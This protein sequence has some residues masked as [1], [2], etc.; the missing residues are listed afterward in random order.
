MHSRVRMSII[1]STKDFA[2]RVQGRPMAELVIGS[3]CSIMLVGR[4]RSGLR[5]CPQWRLGHLQKLSRRQKGWA[6]R[7]QRS[8]CVVQVDLLP[9]PASASGVPKRFWAMTSCGFWSQAGP[10]SF[11]FV[12]LVLRLAHLQASDVPQAARAC[13]CSSC[14]LGSSQSRLADSLSSTFPV[15]FLYVAARR[16]LRS[17]TKT[18]VISFSV[19]EVVPSLMLVDNR[20]SKS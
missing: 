10:C 2:H 13:H 18:N 7:L 14:H 16:L 8:G 9:D 19:Q 6:R 4:D 1:L 17:C 15:C 11:N 12:F 5:T 20:I 3:D